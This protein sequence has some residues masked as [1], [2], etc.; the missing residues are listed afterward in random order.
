MVFSKIPRR[1]KAIV[2]RKVVDRKG[3]YEFDAVLEEWDIPSLKDGQ[4]LVKI[5]AAGFN[6]REVSLGHEFCNVFV[7]NSSRFGFG[8]VCIR[9]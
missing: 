2:L 3:P 8:K 7:N 4:V 1:C 6:H 5:E 9:V